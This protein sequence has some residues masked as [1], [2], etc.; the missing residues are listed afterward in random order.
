MSEFDL[1]PPSEEQRA[2]ATS[3]LQAY[4]R[5]LRTLW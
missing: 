3:G 1:R 5:R 2:L 4:E